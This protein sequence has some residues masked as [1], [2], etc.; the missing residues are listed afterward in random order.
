MVKFGNRSQKKKHEIGRILGNKECKG[1]AKKRKRW[2]IRKRGRIKEE[3]GMWCRK[4]EQMGGFYKRWKGE[5]ALA[6][7]GLEGTNTYKYN[8]DEFV[9]CP[10]FDHRGVVCFQ[11]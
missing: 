6:L 9:N 1:D 2:Q 7:W 4:V 10:W 8:A 3:G 5:V 11:L